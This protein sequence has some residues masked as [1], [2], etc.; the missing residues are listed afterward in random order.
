MA[1]NTASEKRKK[2]MLAALGGLLVIVVAYQFMFGGGQPSSAKKPSN[3]NSAAPATA[4]TPTASQPTAGQSKPASGPPSSPKP[5]DEQDQ[6]IALLLQDLSPLD[7]RAITKGAKSPDK[8]ESAGPDQ[9][10]VKAFADPGKRGSI[11]GEYIEPPKPQPPPPP[12]PPIVLG[13]PQP[14][15]AVAGTPRSFKLTIRGSKIPADAQLFFDGRLKPATRVSDSELTTTVEPGEYASQRT[16]NIDVKSQS[17]PVKNNSN[18]VSFV[19]Q[20]PPQPQFRYMGYVG[21]QAALESNADKKVRL[22]SR[23]SEID[24]WR[25]DAI[26]DKAIDVTH[27]TYE[28]KQH[29]SIIPKPQ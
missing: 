12:P 9:T 7:L 20:A 23:G 2:L 22:Y 19:V 28:I 1:K 10:P 29:L 8:K 26:S 27:K 21:G 6:M 17:D 15:S 11:F 18:T 3:S 14:M 13:A 4:S 25:I 24:G 16:I 5:A